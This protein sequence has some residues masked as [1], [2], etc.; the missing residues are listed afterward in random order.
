MFPGRGMIVHAFSS[1]VSAARSSL[2]VT[3]A[4]MHVGIV[5]VRMRQSRV[6]MAMSV[7]LA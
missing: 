3:V 2:V 4:V 1:G 7:R 6:L 5:R